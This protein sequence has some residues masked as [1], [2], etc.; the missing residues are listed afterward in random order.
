[1]GGRTRR[2]ARRAFRGGQPAVTTA[3]PPDDHRGRPQ[4]GRPGLLARAAGPAAAARRPL[5]HKPPSRAGTQRDADAVLAYREIAEY[6]C[7]LKQLV[8]GARAEPRMP[9]LLLPVRAQ[10]GETWE[11]RRQLGLRFVVIFAGA[12][13][14]VALAAAPALSDPAA[15]VRPRPADVVGVGSGTSEYLLDQLAASYDAAHKSGPY[16]YS[17]DAPASA[18]MPAGPRITPKSGCRPIARPDGSSAGI[19]ALEK[20]VR[21]GGHFC[22]D[23]VRSVTGPAPGR[24]R[25]AGR[26]HHGREQP[27][28]P[29]R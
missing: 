13:A 17:Y 21:D 8:R 11:M 28:R 18:S 26:R 7:L 24:G 22:L 2:A 14:V 20:N 29:G 10:N 12:A 4:R 6:E 5:A 15:G 3:L 19:A 27:G 9:L 25:A 23:F 1:M 16:I